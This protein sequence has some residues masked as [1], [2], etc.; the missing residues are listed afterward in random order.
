MRS[1]ARGLLKMSNSSAGPELSKKGRKKE[2]ILVG[3]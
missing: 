2:F 1:E 3:G